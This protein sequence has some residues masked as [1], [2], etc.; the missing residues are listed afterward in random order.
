MEALISISSVQEIG[1]AP[2]MGV[3]ALVAAHTCVALLGVAAGC[4]W[5]LWRQG[6]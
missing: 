5:H 4:A 3:L 6:R 1:S 2:L